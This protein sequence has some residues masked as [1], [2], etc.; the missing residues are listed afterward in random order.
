M[1]EAERKR[2]MDDVAQAHTIVRK[3]VATDTKIG[4]TQNLVVMLAKAASIGGA[5]FLISRGETTVGTLMAFLGY[6]GGLFG[7][8][9]SLT[10]V[11]QTLRKATISFD[12]VFS[13]LDAEDRL[14]DS[15]H[16]VPVKRVR[17]EVVFRKVYFGYDEER[18]ILNDINL[19][20]RPG[21][22]VAIV[23][24]SGSGKTTL[25]SLLQRFYDPTSG[26]IKVDG[27]DLRFLQQRSLRQQIGVVLQDALV[28]NDTI[29]NNIAYGKPDAT[30]EEIEAAASAANAHGFIMRQAEGYDFVVGERGSRI[31]VGERQRISIARALLKNPSLLIL[32]EA[33]SALDAESEALVQEALDRLI[34]GR[35]SFIIAHR[36]STIVGADRILVL[37]DGRIIESDTH[38]SLMKQGGYY[39]SLI[40]CQ[41]RGLLMAS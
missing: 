11:Y 25:V 35:T 20:V 34:K 23:G 36:L 24:P 14:S 19:H 22:T 8:V 18:M 12:I 40:Q 15:P 29:R 1:E 21:E 6:Q 16:A 28:F 2:F 4:A 31:S 27:V 5:V 33:T 7:P 9:N 38:E 17:G 41:S 13:I 26:S 37:K 32:D 3:G 39:A 10:G 30:Q